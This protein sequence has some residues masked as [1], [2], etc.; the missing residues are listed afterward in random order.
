[1]ILAA[2]DAVDGDEKPTALGHPLRHCVR[3]LCTFGEIHTRQR[4]EDG[5]T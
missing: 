3:Q 4:T 5:C 1:L 2:R